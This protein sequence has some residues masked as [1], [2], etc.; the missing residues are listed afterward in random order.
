MNFKCFCFL[1]VGNCIS[2][3]SLH[4]EVLWYFQEILFLKCTSNDVPAVPGPCGGSSW[5]PCPEGPM[6]SQ[7]LTSAC[8]GALA[9]VAPWLCSAPSCRSLLCPAFCEDPP[10]ALVIPTACS[11]P[12]TRFPVPS[13][14]LCS[15]SVAVITFR[16]TLL[17]VRLPPA[18]PCPDAG[19]PGQGWA[20]W[21]K[22]LAC[23]SSALPVTW[24]TACEHSFQ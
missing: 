1:E 11:P 5:T 19:S 15:P 10:L 18:G 14:D 20:Q 23:N 13:S 12:A 8:P 3:C 21:G 9:L 24:R 22:G 17:R 6:T 7:P 2:G 4:Q 16:H